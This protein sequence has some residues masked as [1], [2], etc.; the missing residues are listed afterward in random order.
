MSD[1]YPRRDQARG[2]WKINDITKNIKGVGTYPGSIGG[3]RAIFFGGWTPGGGVN[4][5]DFVEITTTGNATDFGDMNVTSYGGSALCDGI[6]AVM[7]QN[8]PAIDYVYISSTGNAADFGDTV[9]ARQYSFGASTKTKG[10]SAGGRTPSVSNAIEFITFANTGSAEDFADLHTATEKAGSGNNHVRALYGGGAA[11]ST[12]NAIGFY[13]LASSGNSIDFGD[14]TRSDSYMSGNSSN[15]KVF[16]GGGS[17]GN[18]DT[19]DDVTIASLGNATDFGDLTAARE[20]LSGTG[21]MQRGIFAGGW[22]GSPSNVI[23]YITFS[24]RANAIDFGDLTVGRGYGDY[25]TSQSNSGI[26][27]FQPR[28]PELYSPTGTVV[29]RGGGAGDICI[30]GGGESPSPDISMESIQISILSNASDFGDLITTPI[31]DLYGSTASAERL[32]F[33][34]GSGPS[35]VIQYV[36]FDSKGNAADFGNLT[37]SA[38]STGGHG[39]DTRGLRGG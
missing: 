13:E 22:D 38:R 5:I 24:S 17:P 9:T 30:L 6:R 8:N 16:F 39:N 37:A 11:P 33:L 21:N 2:I 28:A 26:E 15:T 25:A 29:S 12:T 14:L 34:G 36:E 10:F 35:N 19:I 3:D 23:D 4:N 18:V 31:H 7:Y 1:S 27:E 20:A 32:L